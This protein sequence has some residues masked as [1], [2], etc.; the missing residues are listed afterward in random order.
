[1]NF[2]WLSMLMD[3]KEDGAVM[4]VEDLGPGPQSWDSGVVSRFP[5]EVHYLHNLVK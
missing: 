2:Q 4:R 5:S 3:A 1:M